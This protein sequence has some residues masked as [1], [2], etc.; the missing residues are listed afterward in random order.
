MGVVVMV[1]VG[2]VGVSGRKV[3]RS[4]APETVDTSSS[5]GDIDGRRGLARREGRYSD[6]LSESWLFV[7]VGSVSPRIYF[8][9]RSVGLNVDT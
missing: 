2:R 6:S 3:L 8:N 7:A 4:D 5:S 1:V 9:T